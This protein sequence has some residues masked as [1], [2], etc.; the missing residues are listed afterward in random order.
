MSSMRSPSKSSTSVPPLLWLMARS[1]KVSPV[2]PRSTKSPLPRTR[3]YGPS[4]CPSDEGRVHPMR[5]E[6]PGRRVQ[7][8]LRGE[9]GRD[10]RLAGD[11][12]PRPR[13][14]RQPGEGRVG[15]REE[16]EVERR[17]E[18]ELA[19]AEARPLAVVEEGDERVEAVVLADGVG[20]G[21]HDRSPG[22]DHGTRAR[23]PLPGGGPRGPFG[24]VA[25]A[26]RARVLFAHGED[27]NRGQHRAI[28]P[29]LVAEG[30]E[31]LAMDQRLGGALFMAHDE[32]LEGL[33]APAMDFEGLG[34]GPGAAAPRPALGLGLLGGPRHRPG[35]RAPRGRGGGA[36]LL[37]LRP[38]APPPRARGG[39]AARGATLR[40]LRNRVARERREAKAIAG[41]APGAELCT[42][43]VGALG[44]A[45]LLPD[46]NPRRA[47]AAW[48]ALE[49]FLARVAPRGP[50][51]T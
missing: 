29:R 19:L 1:A 15:G 5:P 39:R 14:L 20:D 4:R 18:Q 8:D 21:V 11:V 40:H 16:R 10:G 50:T 49:A 17:V 36:C 13:V 31:T 6:H 37:A 7:G 45:T 25:P 27:A 22:R 46:R 43:A 38:L 30:F 42:P 26:P 35:R 51:S 32:T 3:R 47:S 44:S 23:V 9:E 33:D 34:L 12:H 48:A 28:A 2:E 41:A 24:G